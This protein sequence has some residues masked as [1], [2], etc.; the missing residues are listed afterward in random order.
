PAAPQIPEK[1]FT[2][3]D[4]GAVRDGKTINT[5]AIT[6]AIAAC[7]SAGGGVVVVPAGQFLTG[8]ID[9]ISHMNL[10]IDEGATLVLSDSPEAFVVNGSRHR[11]AIVADKCTDIAIT[12]KGTIDG[13]GN[14]WWVEFRK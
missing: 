1:T 10:R 13:Q 14:R 3:T 6:K 4:Y 8:P 11:N 5:D 9:F 7:K 2:I 12:G